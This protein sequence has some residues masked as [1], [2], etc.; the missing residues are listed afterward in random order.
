MYFF[1]HGFLILQN[2]R[3]LVWVNGQYP[4]ATICVHWGWDNDKDF[5][6]SLS[7]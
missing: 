3:K 5:L 6:E 2:H 7:F 4:Y 1:V